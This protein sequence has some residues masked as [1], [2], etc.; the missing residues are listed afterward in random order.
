ME[1]HA[2]AHTPRKKWTHYFWEFFMLFLAVT[3]GFFVENVREH[4]I[5]KDREKQ[6]MKSLVHDL[7]M[8]SIF[9]SE[10]VK[11]GP[12][13]VR[14]TD[15]LANEMQLKPLKGREKRVYH[16]LSLVSEGVT[17]RY[18]DRTVTQLRN[19][20]GF[21]LVSNPEVSNA[22]L[23]YDVLMREALTYG[24]S[25]ESWGLVASTIEKG[26]T[27]FDMDVAISIYQLSRK[28]IEDLDS[29]PFPSNLELMTYNYNDIKEYVNLLRFTQIT[30]ATKLD[31]SVRAYEKNR[32]LNSLIRSKYHL[33]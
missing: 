26:T 22:V 2:H 31:F 30:D 28:Y 6:F 17:F 11:T 32:K 4:K 8:D 25:N 12:R 19:S 10:N 9:L 27:I 14:Y 29:I 24:T 3:A 23:D 15:S 7:A 21:R 20:G 5:E 1:V 18:Y 16:F 13:I 33:N